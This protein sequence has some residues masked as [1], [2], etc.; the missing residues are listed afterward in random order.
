MDLPD[1]YC[2]NQNFQ[3]VRIDRIKTKPIRKGFDF[4]FNPENPANPDSDNNN[5]VNPLIR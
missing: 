2:L 1:Y 4:D 3:T 5:Q